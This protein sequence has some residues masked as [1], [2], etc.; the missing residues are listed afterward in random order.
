MAFEISQKFH[1]FNA[2]ISRFQSHLRKFYRRKIKMF[3]K[4]IAVFCAFITINALNAASDIEIRKN[5]GTD[6]KSRKAF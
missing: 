2:N 4:K 6:M 3:R 1:N 5:G